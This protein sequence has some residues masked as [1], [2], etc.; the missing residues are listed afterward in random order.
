MPA[1]LACVESNVTVGEICDALR[2]EFGEYR[3]VGSF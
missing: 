2:E 3:G 1:I